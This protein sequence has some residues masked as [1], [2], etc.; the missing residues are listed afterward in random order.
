[1]EVLSASVDMSLILAKLKQRQTELG[2]T[3]QQVSDASGVPYSS[4]TRSPSFQDI[5]AIAAA[6]DLS[7][8]DLT[9]RGRTPAAAAP[10]MT[11]FSIWC[12]GS[13]I[14]TWRRKTAGLR[15]YLLLSPFWFVS[16]LSFS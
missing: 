2:M 14:F 13:I 12:S 6:L 1:M 7:L 16:S 10:R 3:N 8:D 11:G 5:A 9:G 15:F 4:F